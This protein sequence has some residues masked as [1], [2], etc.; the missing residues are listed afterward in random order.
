M[1]SRSEAE[2]GGRPPTGMRAL[3]SASSA[4]LSS[5]LISPR[6]HSASPLPLAGSLTSMGRCNLW[7]SA[8]KP[9]VFSTV[10]GK[11]RVCRVL[12]V[13]CRSGEQIW[14][15]KECL[16]PSAAPKPNVL[17]RVQGSSPKC[18]VLRG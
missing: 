14:N 9:D 17:S 11:L 13:T 4:E 16:W 5:H 1:Q 18:R 10:Q 8:A 2:R 7:P 12:G 3:G 15:C 6:E